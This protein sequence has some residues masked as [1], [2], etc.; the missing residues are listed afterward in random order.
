MGWPDYAI[1]IAS[2]LLLIGGMIEGLAGQKRIFIKSFKAMVV[3][4]LVAIGLI[5]A[6]LYF[7]DI[8]ELGD[9]TD[10]ISRMQLAFWRLSGW[11]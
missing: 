3:V 8:T 1:V 5:A 11:D 2:M 10:L 6:G 7:Q 9:E 4:N